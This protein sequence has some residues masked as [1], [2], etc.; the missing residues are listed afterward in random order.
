MPVYDYRCPVGHTTE[1]NR[2]FDARR[3]PVAC[4]TCGEPA[5]Y[6]FFSDPP[7]PRRTPDAHAEVGEHHRAVYDYRC[8]EGHTTT[9]LRYYRD[10][11]DPVPCETCGAAA[12]YVLSAPWL[13]DTNVMILSYTG[14]K[15]LKAGYVHSHGDMRATRVQAGPGG[16]QGPK[17]K[18]SDAF[19]R[20]SFQV[21]AGAPASSRIR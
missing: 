2:P 9:T 14:S 10:H 12:T 3:E 8:P 17:E 1:Q 19:V 6:A 4:A 15:K 21:D 18:A 7:K 20:Q 5:G 11:L 13:N 16:A